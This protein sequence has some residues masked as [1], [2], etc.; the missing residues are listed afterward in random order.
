DFSRAEQAGVDGTDA[1]V[2]QALVEG[3]VAYEARFGRV[4]LIRAAGRSSADILDELDRRLQNDTETELG[5]VVGQLGE[6]AILRL[7][8]VVAS[9]ARSARTCSTR[10]RVG[11]APASAGGCGGRASPAARARTGAPRPH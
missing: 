11:P 3:N 10:R 2:A 9:W 1:A 7:R 8:Q 5:E 4:F 6:I